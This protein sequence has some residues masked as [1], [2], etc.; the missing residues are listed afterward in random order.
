MKLIIDPLYNPNSQVDITSATKLALGMPIASFLGSG[1]N[2]GN[3][4]SVG[5]LETRRTLARQLY[6]HAALFEPFNNH[7]AFIN[8][9]LIL[10]EALDL[11]STDTKKSSGQKVTY[12]VIDNEGII[13][14]P[15]TFDLS[16][17]WK[18][19]IEYD[20]LSLWYDIFDPGDSITVHIVL[21]LPEIGAN[22]EYTQTPKKDISVFYNGNC[23]SID[24]LVE[25]LE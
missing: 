13:D 17:F 22:F 9:R 20:E 25:I 19:H 7:P 6:L 8:H 18:D 3:F 4:N 11:T 14:L 2:R 10:I 5:D 24:E 12:A 16:V 1:G 23:Q 21:T 15:K